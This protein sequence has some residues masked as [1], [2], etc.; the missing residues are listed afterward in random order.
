MSKTM[1]ELRLEDEKRKEAEQAEEKRLD[2]KVLCAEITF[3]EKMQV[4]LGISSLTFKYE[5][6]KEWIEEH[7]ENSDKKSCTFTIKF[8]YATNRWIE[9]LPEADI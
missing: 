3:P 5:E 1:E 8:F 7:T 4:E 9:N 2:K 6:V